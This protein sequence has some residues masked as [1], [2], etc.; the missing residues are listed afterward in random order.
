M[1][2]KVLFALT[3]HDTLGDTGRK[4]GFYVPEV[5]HPARVF[6]EAGFEVAYVSVKGGAAPQDGINKDDPVVSAFLADEAV[7]EALAATPAPGDLKAEDY[8]VIYFAGGHGTMWDFP[9]SRELAEL[10]AA[11][12]ERGGVVAAVCHGPA[13]LVNLRLSDGTYLV[14]GKQISSFTDEEEAAVGLTEVVPFLLESKLAERGAKITKAPDFTEHAVADSR[15]V[16]GQNPASAAKVAE[17]AIR[18]LS[19][20]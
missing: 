1:S 19:A 17:L 11:V 9:G 12:Y 18:E 13:G 4:T 16:T 3:S 2:K 15:V 10:A 6:R 8:D 5:A 14:E 20:A 7:Q